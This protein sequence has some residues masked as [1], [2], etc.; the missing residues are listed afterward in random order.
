MFECREVTSVTKAQVRKVIA[1]IL[2]LILRIVRVLCFIDYELD[3]S[4]L[5]VIER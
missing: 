3:K 2:L 4:G 1:S 5:S